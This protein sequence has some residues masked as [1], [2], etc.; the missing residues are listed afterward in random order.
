MYDSFRVLVCSKKDSTG[1]IKHHLAGKVIALMTKQA[2]ID[3]L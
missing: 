2:I 1:R 3:N